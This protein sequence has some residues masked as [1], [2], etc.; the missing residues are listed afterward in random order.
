MRTKEAI[1][2]VF[3]VLITLMVIG[4]VMGRGLPFFEIQ[5]VT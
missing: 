2:S 1:K 5:G 4:L 3:A